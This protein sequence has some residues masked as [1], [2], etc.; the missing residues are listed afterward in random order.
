MTY[1]GL[2]LGI[3][4]HTFRSHNYHSHFY[5]NNC[6]TDRPLE[7]TV[8]PACHLLYFISNAILLLYVRSQY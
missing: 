6:H 8:F 7:M 2:H 3:D 5:I 1:H 4:H